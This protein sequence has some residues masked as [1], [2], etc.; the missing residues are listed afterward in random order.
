[1]SDPQRLYKRRSSFSVRGLSLELTRRARDLCTF[2]RTRSPSTNANTFSARSPNAHN[3]SSI[4]SEAAQTLRK[5]NRS[6]HPRRRAPALREFTRKFYCIAF[7]CAGPAAPAVCSSNL[8]KQRHFYRISCRRSKNLKP[9]AQT[10]QLIA[11]TQSAFADNSIRASSPRF[12]LR[13]ISASQSRLLIPISCAPSSCSAHL[14]FL[15]LH[16]ASIPFSS[17]IYRNY[18][19]FSLQAATIANSICS[20]FNHL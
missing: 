19:A 8:R 16:K 1:M 15:A 11:F 7:I 20:C 4:A 2:E 6:Y 10:L 9:S 14:F 5:F 18:P 13:E 3:F 12:A 17:A